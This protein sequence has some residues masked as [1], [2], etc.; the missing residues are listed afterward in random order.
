MA[1]KI[2]GQ[3]KLIYWLF[4]LMLALELVQAVF[5]F[6]NIYYFRVLWVGGYTVLLFFLGFYLKINRIFLIIFTL[7]ALSLVVLQ[8]FIVWN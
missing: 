7:V 1:H 3:L 5:K 4:A 6:Y 2:S 8:Y